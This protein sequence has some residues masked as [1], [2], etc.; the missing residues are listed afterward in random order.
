MRLAGKT[1]CLTPVKIKSDLVI[2]GKGKAGLRLSKY[3]FEKINEAGYP[4]H[5]IDCDLEK[6]E[7]TVI[8]AVMFGDG[9]EVICRYKAFGS[10][11]RRYGRY[12]TEG[13][14]FEQ[15]L[16]EVTLKDDE[17]G[18]PLVSR[19]IAAALGVVTKDEYR[20]LKELT[21][22]ICGVIKDELA[23]KGLELI[24]IKLEFGRDSNGKIML[25]DEVSGD[26]MRV[27]KDGKS[28][29]P[30]ELTKTATNN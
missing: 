7:M 8:P 1:V 19:E 28:V 6:A 15:P 30:I 13:T 21:R 17:R 26:I 2:D 10:F 22:N 18:D 11:V 3:F 23:Q 24:D 12:I 27:F 25:V 4:T 5:F 16:V 9:V 20:T 14:V 29:D